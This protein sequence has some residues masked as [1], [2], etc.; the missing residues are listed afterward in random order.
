MG[1]LMYICAEKT[2]EQTAVRD[3]MPDTTKTTTAIEL[4]ARDLARQF[5]RRKIFSGVNITLRAGES[6]AIV[7][8][9]GSGKSTLLKILALV[10]SPTQ[11][12]VE[13]RRNGA[14]L[15]AESVHAEV[16]FAAPYLRLYEEFSAGEHLE[17]TASLRGD[18]CSQTEADA[19]LQHCGLDPLRREAVAAFSSGMQQRLKLAT[20]IQ[21]KPAILFLDEP[22]ATL[23]EAGVE[24]VQK[25]VREQTARG[26]SV[27][28]ATNDERDRAMCARV[29]ELEEYVR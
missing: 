4:N 6:L 15:A 3:K 20:A 22:S 11:G 28:I 12:T 1:G 10:L 24:L 26:G 5:R 7:G 2:S 21:H 25:I 13:Y 18:S 23:D 16:G 19:L 8:P 9:N 17:L 29:L 27:V 14:P